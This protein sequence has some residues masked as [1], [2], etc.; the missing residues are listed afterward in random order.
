MQ[1]MLFCVKCKKIAIVGQHR[2]DASLNAQ[3]KQKKESSSLHT[4]MDDTSLPD[5]TL[6]LRIEWCPW[7]KAERSIV[8]V[9]SR[10]HNQYS[11]MDSNYTEHDRFSCPNPA[12][13]VAQ[14][15][16]SVCPETQQ[17]FPG[18]VRPRA[19][20]HAITDTCPLCVPDSLDAH[21]VRLVQ[22]APATSALAQMYD[23][24]PLDAGCLWCCD[25]GS[26]SYA[27]RRQ[28]LE[29][30]QFWAACT[31]VEVALSPFLGD[32]AAYYVHDNGTPCTIIYGNR[33]SLDDRFIPG[34]YVHSEQQFFQ[35]ESWGIGL[36]RPDPSDFRNLS[37]MAG[38]SVLRVAWMSACHRR[39]GV[40]I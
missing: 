28:V 14:H 13:P 6:S 31:R 12:V 18:Y 40:M 23:L 8:E 39:R 38:M 34:C 26:P 10:H 24:G 7:C 30:F 25:D 2:Q 36:R 1:A 37:P 16:L 22:T 33:E 19:P 5:T 11:D 9:V 32:H 17:Q 29:W 3:R 21:I 20:F 35:V 27:G 15:H 4:S